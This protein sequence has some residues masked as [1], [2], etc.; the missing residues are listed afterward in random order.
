MDMQD[1]RK[2]RNS[3]TKIRATLKAVGNPR[4][5]AMTFDNLNGKLGESKVDR[6][7]TGGQIDEIR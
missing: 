5:R 7:Q 2:R 3:T 4:Q 6:S 1:G